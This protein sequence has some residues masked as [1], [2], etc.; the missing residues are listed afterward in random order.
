MGATTIG[1]TRIG[2]TLK[3]TRIG[4]VSTSTRVGVAIRGYYDRYSNI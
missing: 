4:V 1:D 3:G 2:V